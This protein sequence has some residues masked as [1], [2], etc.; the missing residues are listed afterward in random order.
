MIAFKCPLCQASLMTADTNA[1]AKGKCANCGGKIVIPQDP[2][3]PPAASGAPAAGRRK[4]PVVEPA[5]VQLT[6]GRVIGT[7]EKVDILIDGA[8]VGSTRPGR[9][10]VIPVAPGR[11]RLTVASPNRETSKDFVARPLQ[12]CAWRV[13]YGMAGLSLLPPWEGPPSRRPTISRLGG[14][15]AGAGAL[16][17]VVGFLAENLLKGGGAQDLGL[18]DMS[19]LAPLLFVLGSIVF[20]TGGIIGMLSRLRSATSAAQA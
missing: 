19:Q 20:V 6:W 5:T 7:L 15:L 4:G 12:A 11:H 10:V 18:P 14:F 2:Q 1:G 16:S 3:A 13:Q 9:A 8:P 17:V